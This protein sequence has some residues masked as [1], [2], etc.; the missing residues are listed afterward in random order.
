MDATDI[1]VIVPVYNL[2]RF[3]TPLL[4][5]L[6]A[7]DTGNY[8]AE[9]VFVINNCSDRSEEV[10]R[11]SGLKCRIIHCEKQGCG[12]AR[13]AGFD[14]TSGKYVWFMDGDDWLLSNTAIRDAVNAMENDSLDILRIPFSKEKYHGDFYSMVW[15]Y[16][17]RREYIKDIRFIDRQPDEDCVFMDEVFAKAGYDTATYSWRMP[18]MLRELYYYNYMRPGSNMYRFMSGEKI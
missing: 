9:Y 6:K 3:I 4:D 15:Q 1:S 18:R 14:A 2:E 8:V 12:P 11:E 16:V 5:S 17:F 13:N 7:Q 10:I